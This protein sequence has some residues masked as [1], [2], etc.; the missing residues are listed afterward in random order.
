VRPEL[1]SDR[2]R[3]LSR[4][5]GLRVI[6]LHLVRHT[7][8]V[9]MNRAGVAPVDAAPLLGH[10]VDVYISTY[11][12]PSEQGARRWS[13]RRDPVRR[14][15]RSFDRPNRCFGFTTCHEVHSRSS[16]CEVCRRWEADQVGIPDRIAGT[17][18]LQPEFK[19]I[20]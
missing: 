16:R 4:Q 12:R 18:A 15:R 7:L 10:T 3:R 17:A 6:H 14:T 1:Y 9:A 5:A 13:R 8:A 19:A 2:F 20:R 11:L